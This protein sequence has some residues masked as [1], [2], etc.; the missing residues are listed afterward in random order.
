MISLII[1]GETIFF[2]PF[3]LPRVFRPTLLDVFQID[4]LELGTAF[5]AYGIVAMISYF[6]GGPLADR[7][8]ARSL[9]AWALVATSLGGVYMMTIPSYM[10]VMGV[11]AFWG[12]TTIFLFW[13]ALIKATREWGGERSQGKAFGFLDGG[14]GLS[15]ALIGFVGIAILASMLPDNVASAIPEKQTASF[16]MVILAFSVFTFLIA[17]LVWFTLPKSRSGEEHS[18]SRDWKGIRR[19]LR[20]PVVWMQ[21]IIILCGYVGYKIT[22]DFPL[23]AQDVLGFNEVNAALVGSMALLMRPLVALIAGFLA[24]RYAPSSLISL[25]FILVVISGLLAGSGVLVAGMLLPYIFL[26]LIVTSGIYA[27]RSLYFTVMNEG[28]IPLELTGTAVGVV[29]V[30]GYTPDIFVGPGMGWLLDSYPGALGHQYLF[31]FL[32]VF[33]IIGFVASV[34]FRRYKPTL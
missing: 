8:S 4:N 21:M 31:L 30:I 19:I 33:G 1:S 17:L 7:F 12:F 25:S 2:L 28:K 15:A 27:L 11:Y 14:R 5:S 29:S 26:F 23:Y 34:L 20:M 10:G 24:D 6:F 18:A 13:A 16:R 22:D 3:V 32:S 9:M